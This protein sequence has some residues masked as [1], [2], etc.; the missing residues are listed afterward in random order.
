MSRS[1]KNIS[2]FKDKQQ[3]WQKRAASKRMR[4]I[5]IAEPVGDRSGF[6]KK[7]SDSYD[8]C[9][10]KILPDKDDEKWYKKGFRK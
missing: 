2:I 8:I 3:R 7:V 4:R 9:D 5:P 1:K 6:Q 10:Y